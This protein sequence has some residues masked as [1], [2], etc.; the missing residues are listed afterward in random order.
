MAETDAP[1]TVGGEPRV[2]ETRVGAAGATADR[3]LRAALRRADPLA[4]A[5]LAGA[6]VA[7]SFPVYWVLAS[8]VPL[9]GGSEGHAADFLIYHRAGLRVLADPATLYAD[10]SFLY[11]P[12][13]GVLF[14][15]AVQVPLAWGYLAFA[16]MNLAVLAGCLRL[17]ERLVPAPPTGWA[18]AAVWTVA[19]ASAPALQNLKYG[20]VNALVLLVALGFLVLLRE[21]PAWAG[22][23]L[24]VGVW[25]KV[26]P[27]V[28]GLF[29]LT[30]RTWPALVGLGLG[31]VGIA[32]VLLPVFPADL[33]VEYVTRV[34]AHLTDVTTTSTLNAGLPAVVERL[35]LPAD[36]LLVYVSAPFGPVAQAVGTA[37]LVGGVGAVAVA[38]WRGWRREWAAFALLAVVPITSTLGWEYTFT[39]ALPAVLAM[40]LAAREGALPVRLAALGAMLVLFLQKPPE[41]VMKWAVREIPDPFLDAFAARFLIALAVLAGAAWAASR[42]AAR[43]SS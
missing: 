19:F 34:F 14:A 30:R 25:L 6:F 18:R 35:R 5:F 32:V 11:P 43:V 17:W 37:A 9:F 26:Y 2:G 27:A 3:T 15:L 41:S 36:A 38:W 8:V 31:L 4:W 7:V 40:L 22:A 10:S 1:E 24:A 29:M 28:L 16:A 21:R 12:P 42:R 39:L 33:Y 23:L 20:Q 13:S